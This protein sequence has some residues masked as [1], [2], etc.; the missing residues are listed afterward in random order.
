MDKTAPIIPG[1]SAAGIRIGT[2]V[3]AILKKQEIPFITEKIQNP[4][5][6]HSLPLMRYRS[7]M[8]DLWAEAGVIN[9]IMVHNGYTGQLRSTIGLGS[10]I[11]DIEKQIGPWGEDEED[12]FVIQNLP[13][14]C[15]AVEGYF[16]DLKDPA[17]RLA[18]I[19]EM[20]VFEIKYDL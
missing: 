12:N 15:F 6:A 3:E 16:S 10:T 14:L 17:L 5:V 13:G 20:Y 7:A 8:V 9:Q 18:K 4:F 19:I 1:Q 11:A 2:P